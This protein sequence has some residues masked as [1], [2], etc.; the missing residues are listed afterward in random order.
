MAPDHPKD[1]FD[2]GLGTP[3]R[4]YIILTSLRCTRTLKI[5]VVA[6]VYAMYGY[7]N[8]SSKPP[9]DPYWKFLSIVDIDESREQFMQYRHSSTPS[10][11]SQSP[12]SG[13]STLVFPSSSSP[14]AV[15]FTSVTPS[16]TLT[17][18]LITAATSLTNSPQASAVTSPS[19]SQ[20]ISSQSPPV[21]TMYTT[22]AITPPSPST[23]MFVVT[24][25]STPTPSISST[26]N[27][28]DSEK[29][30]VGN[31][32]ADDEDDKSLGTILSQVRARGIFSLLC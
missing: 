27:K 25:T 1:K 26:P 13:S 2:V 16:S 21:V 17:T 6:S 11:S 3:F 24:T 18:S 5:S 30:L 28:G 10:S 9:Q 32:S 22:I 7:Q 19:D 14:S 23:S 29:T 12:G 4:K 20:S 8:A 15:S 31:L